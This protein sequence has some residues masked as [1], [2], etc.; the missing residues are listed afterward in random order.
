MILH[1][2]CHE[3]FPLLCLSLGGTIISMVLKKEIMM[4]QVRMRGCL[5]IAVMTVCFQCLPAQAT[6]RPNI[7]YFYADDMGW[8]SIGP[9]GQDDRRASGLANVLTPTIDRLAEEGVNFR[10]AYG[11]MVCSP[12]RSSQQT[13]FH[14]GHTWADRN[15]PDNAKKAIRA[16]DITM[17]DALK[18]AGYVTGYW[19]KWGYGA[20]KGKSNPVIQNVQ[21]L[22]SSHGYDYVLAELHHVRAHTFFQPTLWSFKPGDSQMGLVLNSLVTYADN[23]GYPESPANQSHSNYPAT[24]YCDDSYAFAALDFVRTQAQAY[25]AGGAP[26][27]ALFAAQIPHGPYGDITRLP[28]WDEFYEGDANFANLSN[29]A[30]HWAAMVTRLDA[31]IKNILAVLKDPDGDG[32]TSD[33]VADN[34]IVVFQ[35]DNGAAGNKAIAEVGS[36]ANLRGRK[37][38]I[39]EGGIR[40][41]MVMRWPAKITSNSVLQAN[42][43]SNLVFDVTDLLPT[44]CELAGVKTP[45]GIDGV[46]LASTLTGE[47]HQRQRDFVIHEAG[48]YSSI[49][50][51]NHKLVRTSTS[52][53]LFDLGNDPTESTDIAGANAALVAELEILLLRERVTEPA[54]SANTYHNWTGADGANA[55]DAANW[56][57]YIYEN[58]G[59]VYDTDSGDPRIPWI[60]KMEN[61]TLTDQ[62]AIL[63]TS[64]ETLS[65][66]ISGN[67]ASGAIQTISFKPGRKLTGHNEIRLSPLAKVELNGGALASNR[68]VDLFQGASLNGFGTVD[69]T[70]YNQGTL[71]ITSGMTGLTVNGDYHQSAS[72][73]LNAVIGGHTSLAVSGA[74]SI[75]GTL[76]C[77]L[78][79]GFSARPGDRFT[80]LSADSVT[81]Q[82]SSTQGMVESEGHHFRILYTADT[83][84]LERAS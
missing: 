18:A 5:L 40:I 22:P 51:G 37:G 71:S 79:A 78:P 29:E 11:C 24:A 63:D 8:G 16:D 13:G 3:Y 64:I 34:T 28:K 17:G 32:N 72:A 7:L 74:A 44:F 39:W 21:T 4:L 76:N 82:F 15:N 33:S 66:E 75:D 26:F 42:T 56:S 25:N 67:V 84:E 49:I 69:A 43:D 1:K 19:G 6:R 55:S 70:L 81:G 83:V 57:D 14:Q 30:K 36:N 58:K 53:Q 35:S 27:F 46:S 62:T 2:E 41:P 45:L 52:L 31:H 23:P 47:G 9:N 20:S 10:R 68:W 50:R 73:T 48:K 61:K 38:Q 54:W 65:I 60:A 77:T 59:I 12:A 80:I